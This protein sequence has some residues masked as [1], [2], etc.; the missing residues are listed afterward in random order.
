M[1]PQYNLITSCRS[2]A[3]TIMNCVLGLQRHSTDGRHTSD[4]GCDTQT[5]SWCICYNSI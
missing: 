1:K 4:I 3:Q 2:V 5:T